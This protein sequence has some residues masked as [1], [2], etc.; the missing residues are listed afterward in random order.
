MCLFYKILPL[1]LNIR[2]EYQYILEYIIIVQ[3]RCHHIWM[4]NLYVFSSRSLSAIRFSVVG[5]YKLFEI[6]MVFC[7]KIQ[8]PTRLFEHLKSLV[9]VA[10]KHFS[11]LYTNHYF[12]VCFKE[13]SME[14]KRDIN[15]H[16]MDLENKFRTIWT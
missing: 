7:G 6:S 8:F 4:R 12:T 13:S 5:N 10:S 14:W 2:K 16:E 1:Y 3:Y 15:F 11:V 9:S